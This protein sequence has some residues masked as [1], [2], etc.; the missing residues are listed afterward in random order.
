NGTSSGYGQL[1]T[2]DEVYI[3]P[4]S[5]L[6]I[7]TYATLYK[8]NA[9][10]Y[11]YAKY[12]NETN[13]PI[14]GSNRSCNIKFNL[15]GPWTAP[16]NMTY[17]PGSEY[18]YFNRSFGSFQLVPYNV[19]CENLDNTTY[20]TL[21]KKETINLQSTWHYR[22]TITVNTRDY[23][24]II[25]ENIFLR[26][27]FS[28]YMGNLEVD[29]NSIRIYDS[30]NQEIPSR[31]VFKYNKHEGLIWFYAQGTQAK[32][33]KRNYTI[34]FDST[35]YPKTAASYSK[36]APP[37]VA[38]QYQGGTRAYILGNYNG[39]F[40]S[41]Y[42]NTLPVPGSGSHNSEGIADF[43]NDGDWDYVI[44]RYGDNTIYF[45]ENHG[46][47]NGF[48]NFSS[49][50]PLNVPSRCGSHW[51]GVAVADFNKDGNM[52]FVGESDCYQSWDI[53]VYLGRGDGTFTY[54]GNITDPAPYNSR[55]LAVADFD[56]DSNM[57]FA[58][59]TH[60]ETC[61]AWYIYYGRGDGTFKKGVQK[62]CLYGNNYNT[63]AMAAVDANHDG[64][65]DVVGGGAYYPYSGYQYYRRWQQNPLSANQNLTF[66]D[67]GY[68][69]QNPVGTDL[70]NRW[71]GH[72]WKEGYDF[73]HDGWDDVIGNVYAD[74]VGG[75]C[76][77]WYWE[78]TKAN[79]TFKTGRYLGNGGTCWMG[80]GQVNPQQGHNLGYVVNISDALFP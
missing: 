43:D 16:I 8:P 29:N 72:G 20:K 73:N 75:S 27:N 61:N 52:D 77:I 64:W 5:S 19:T 11:F 51:M 59:G 4:Y 6:K 18:Y 50:T 63:Y 78:S 28:K 67:Y 9:S 57:D 48:S 79:Y 13:Q 14:Q 42:V 39:S 22:T 21:T 65:T 62:G 53:E 40:S 76:G 25:N 34:Y 41:P 44:S 46:G 10:I 49:L 70:M 1:N 35:Y 69:T 32:N 7:W 71:N 30:Y 68:W 56:H 3:A 24:P 80:Q 74:N 33:S 17:N 37:D 12:F 15:T 31:M 66:I 45:A 26:I 54:G 60:G 47:G 38:M 36:K 58:Q 23:G 2:T 55:D